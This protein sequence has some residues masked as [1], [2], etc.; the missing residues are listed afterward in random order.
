M[1]IIIIFVLLVYNLMAISVEDAAWLLNAETDLNKAYKVAKTQKKK[2][3]LLVIV[4]D[5][6]NW[7]S[8]MV[9]NTLRDKTIQANLE[10]MVTVVVDS[11]NTLPK[12]FKTKLTPTMF[13][14]DVENKKSVLKQT[15]YIKKGTFLIDIISASEM[16]E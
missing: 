12:T 6:C 14:I 3:L 5:G 4:K 1:K 13:F 11:N 2:M 9:E 15:G 16:V 8:M 10:D 7:C